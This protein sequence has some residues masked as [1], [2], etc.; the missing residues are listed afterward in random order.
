MIYIVFAHPYPSRSRANRAL[1]DAVRNLPGVEVCMLYERYPDFDVDIAAEQAALT[2]ARLIVW[3][4]PVY[5]YSTPSLLK[6]WCDKVLAPGWAYGKGGSA[7]HGKDFL[8]VA[9]T[10][11]D[12]TAYSAAGVHRRPFSDFMAPVEET[13]H[14][15]GMN[16]QAP[17]V[18]HDA[19]AI[20]ATTLAAQALRLQQRLADWSDG[21]RGTMERAS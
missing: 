17:F 14:F 19:G 1:L 10:G 16:W 18:L 7:L 9:T 21:G 8:W 12:A 6:H 13:A 2:R 11:G 15:C 20:D 4:H 5:W 3:M